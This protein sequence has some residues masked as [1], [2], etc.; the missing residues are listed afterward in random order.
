[1]EHKPHSHST[2]PAFGVLGCHLPPYYPILSITVRVSL[3]IQQNLWIREPQGG[4]S[5]PPQLCW[6]A[7]HC[8]HGPLSLA[9]LQHEPG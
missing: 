2:G 8:P 5:R 3:L 7:A 1:M 6:T 9:Q 4:V